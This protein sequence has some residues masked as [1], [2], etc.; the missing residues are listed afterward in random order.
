M[1]RHTHTHTLSCDGTKKSAGSHKVS[2]T[3]ILT[4]ALAET[5][6]TFKA[7]ISTFGYLEYVITKSG[8]TR[9]EPS[10]QLGYFVLWNILPGFSKKT[11]IH[12]KPHRYLNYLRNPQLQCCSQKCRAPSTEMCSF[13]SCQARNLEQHWIGGRGRHD[14]YAL[15]LH[16]RWLFFEE[17]S[18]TNLGKPDHP[19]VTPAPSLQEVVEN[20]PG[21]IGIISS[22]EKELLIR[23][24]T[25]YLRFE[26]KK[27]AFEHG[28][29]E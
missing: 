7:H 25:T 14:L 3:Y 16:R 5:M 17:H 13:W 4:W 20:E 21:G 9:E 24:F 18:N 6:G 11:T 26:E 27:L 8:T 23:A 19:K 2:K 15:V 1:R 22:R 10:S 12:R 29:F 28:P